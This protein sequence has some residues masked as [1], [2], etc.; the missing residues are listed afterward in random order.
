MTRKTVSLE[1]Q[2]SPVHMK[3]LELIAEANGESVE[4]VAS[5]MLAGTIEE[6]LKLHLDEIFEDVEKEGRLKEAV[7]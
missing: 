7:Q 6:Q 5:D 4:K 3:S 1:V 2:L